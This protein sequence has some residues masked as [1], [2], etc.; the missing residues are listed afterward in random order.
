MYDEFFQKAHELRAADQP[1]VTVVVVR[2]E[3]PTSGK[4][5]D[6]AIVTRDGTMHGWVG[7][8]CAQPTVIEQAARALADGAPR[9]I[10]L[11]P[12]PGAEPVPPGVEEVPMTCFS[13]GTLDLFIEPHHPRPQ[14]LIVG[15][16]P[17]ARALADLGRAMS[18][19]VTVVDPTGAEASVRAGAPAEAPAA[20]PHAA[21][22]P[23]G[24][25]RVLT[26]LA[27]I[28]AHATGLTFAV[29]ATHGQY[30]EPALEQ[31][32]STDVPYVGLVASKSRGRAVLEHLAQDGVDEGTL[33]RVRFPA[34][35]DIGA[36]RG[37]E[38][39]VSIIAEIVQV[40]RGLGEVAWGAAG[41]AAPD[42]V[43]AG[44]AVAASV[45]APGADVA[46]AA[47]EP[48]AD[49]AAG[50]AG[51]TVGDAPAGPETATDPICGMSVEVA[52]ALHTYEHEG[53][54][55]YFCCGGCR[56][57]FAKEPEAHLVSG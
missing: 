44:A 40:K 38:I 14:L 5:G 51:A 22:A 33:A 2:A 3:N 29:V 17:V 28:P 6:R 41:T 16:L 32:L 30:D 39:A 45:T 56:S 21:A 31:V 27:Q 19:G 48:E 23:A 53:V 46:G 57:R 42:E 52:R 35:L 18:Y 47:P 13:G 24:A 15:T 43:S 10:R 7:G 12:R 50:G 8:S 34:G 4:P 36:R 37:D 20:A 9:L 55:Y 11:S 1:F 25:D 49:A 26:D 54:T